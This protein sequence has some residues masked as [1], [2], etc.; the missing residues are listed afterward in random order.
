[1]FCNKVSLAPVDLIWSALTSKLTK[2][3]GPLP[4]A[5]H[6]CPVIWPR[7]I[8]VRTQRNHRLDRETHALLG[9]SYSLVF[10]IM[11]DARRTVE[12]AVDAVTTISLDDT[13]VSFLDMLLDHVPII[14]KK[15][16]W[17]DEPDGCVQ[18]FSGGLNHPNGIGVVPC[19]LAD[20]VGLVEITVIA[21]MIQCDIYVYDVTIHKHPLIRNSMADDLIG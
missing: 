19:F 14:P 15:G 21:S 12:Q 18:A 6:T 9:G 8:S 11:W 13:T 2:L 5:S 10:G 17:L 16:S 1:M 4:I 20:V 3:S 7:L